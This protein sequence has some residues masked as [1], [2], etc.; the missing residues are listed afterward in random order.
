MPELKKKESSG[1]FS[2]RFAL[3]FVPMEREEEEKEEVEEEEKAE[4][5]KA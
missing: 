2:S 5:R 4:E 1:D 3:L